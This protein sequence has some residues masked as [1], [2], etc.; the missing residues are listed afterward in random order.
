L[1]PFHF[2][3]PVFRA[4]L[5]RRLALGVVP[6]VVKSSPLLFGFCLWIAPSSLDALLAKANHLVGFPF[7]GHHH[8]R[9]GSMAGGS[10]RLVDTREPKLLHFALDTLRHLGHSAVGELHLV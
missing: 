4:E 1:S 8:M 3:A 10:L 7:L 5:G 6:G 2:V 9:F